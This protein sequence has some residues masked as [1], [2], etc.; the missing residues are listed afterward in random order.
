MG[1]FLDF[2]ESREAGHCQK[3]GSACPQHE[4]TKCSRC[5]M[6]CCGKCI[7]HR[8]LYEGFYCNECRGIMEG[9]RWTPEAKRAREVATKRYIASSRIDKNRE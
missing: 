5:K 8:K 3:C 1:V 2:I 6:N 9:E 4:L 7:T